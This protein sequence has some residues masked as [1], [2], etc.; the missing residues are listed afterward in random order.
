M[1]DPL[2]QISF[3]AE[4]PIVCNDC[5]RSFRR[6]GDIKRHKCLSERAKPISEQSGAV[7]CVYCQK[8][9]RS[10]GGLA[11]HQRKCNSSV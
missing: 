1:T 4:Q 11:V 8:W 6:S 9:M 2:T 7:Q 5:G 3:N 10:A